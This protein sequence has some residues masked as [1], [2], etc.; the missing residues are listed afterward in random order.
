MAEQY[1]GI[2]IGVGLTTF[3]VFLG[4]SV[5]EIFTKLKDRKARDNMQIELIEEAKLNI[6]ILGQLSVEVPEMLANGNIP[7][8]IPHRMILAAL[9]PAISSGAIR[10][11][12]DYRVQRRWR[13]IASTCE[14]FNGFV[15]NT[16]QVAIQLLMQPPN[17]LLTIRYRLARLS[18][19]AIETQEAIKKFLDEA[20]SG[21]KAK[22]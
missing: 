22:P 1:V 17:A 8:R 20:E 21:P 10:L 16:E 14:S 3:G 18:E 6:A 15:T 13:L 5:S 11:L 2:A 4:A 19:Q 9:N 12:S 7:V